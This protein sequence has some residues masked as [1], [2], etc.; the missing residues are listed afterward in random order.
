MTGTTTIQAPPAGE[1]SHLDIFNS[2]YGGGFVADGLNFSNGSLV[3]QRIDDDLDQS[4]DLNG[5]DARAVGKF[6]DLDQSFGYLDDSGDYVE[7]FTESGDGFD[8]EGSI[9][10]VSVNSPAVFARKGV[11][12]LVSSDVASNTDGRDHLVT[13]QILGLSD[14]PVYVLFFEDL[15]G[16]E[17][18]DDFQDL[19]VEVRSAPSPAAA[20]SGLVLIG[21][22]CIRRRR[23]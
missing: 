17:V 7:L 20:L 12:G 11:N 23:S 22:L 18:D 4:F 14:Q 15:F 10:G 6:A 13:Y 8:T 2:V 19:V 3:A 16:T 5:F 9:E 21:G 1:A